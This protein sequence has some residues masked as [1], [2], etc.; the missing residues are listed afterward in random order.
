MF[1]QRKKTIRIAGAVCL[2]TALFFCAFGV[3]TAQA[4]GSGLIIAPLPEKTGHPGSPDAVETGT[5]PLGLGELRRK[6]SETFK[7]QG[8]RVKQVA[9]TFDDVPDPRFTPQVLQVLR[10]E[11]VKATFFVVGH[12]AKKYPELLRKI[13]A[14]GHIIGNHSFSH[15]V[16]KKRSLKQFQSEILRTEKII[17]GITGYRPKL[18]RPPYGEI[19]EE[20]VRWAKQHGYTIVNWN[21]DSLDWKGLDQEKVVQNVLGTVGPGSIV[22]QH[23]GGGTGS[24]L[25]GTIEALPEIIHTLRAKG[26]HFVTVPELLNIPKYR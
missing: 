8:P 1:R 22:L 26:Y 20:Q 11:G 5:K 23:A 6:Y 7:F 15:P 24:N 4:A 2:I 21:V 10:K 25:T 18:I 14:E 3:D 17:L 13:H 19:N 12:R 16:F 9:L